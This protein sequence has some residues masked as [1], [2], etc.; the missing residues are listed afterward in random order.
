[1]KKNLFVS[2]KI[3]LLITAV[4]LSSCSKDEPDF[5][6]VNGRFNQ[7]DPNC[8]GFDCTEYIQFIGNSEADFAFGDIISRVTYRLVDRKIQLSV[9]V[10]FIIEDERILVRIE[11]NTRWL[12]L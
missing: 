2:L 10:S 5:V 3:F 8:E 11:D 7:E 4:S 12:K 9:N 6:E 1:M